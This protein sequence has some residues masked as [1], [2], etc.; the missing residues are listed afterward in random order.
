MLC[1]VDMTITFSQHQ[2]Q[3]AYHFILSL[4]AQMT[5]CSCRNEMASESKD[6]T[7]FCQNQSKA[8]QNVFCRSC[9]W[10]AGDQFSPR[11]V[12]NERL[13]YMHLRVITSKPWQDVKAH[14]VA[15]IYLSAVFSRNWITPVQPKKHCLRVS[16]W[17]GGDLLISSLNMAILS[18]LPCFIYFFHV[19]WF[20]FL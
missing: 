5:S 10:L 1:T 19:M 3:Q 7:P 18:F 14:G 9:C 6:N 2:R 15:K 13:N 17:K 16:T 20:Y 4:K 8:A 11:T 12:H